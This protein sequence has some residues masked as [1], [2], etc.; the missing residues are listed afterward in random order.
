[1]RLVTMIVQHIL[2]RKGYCA[3]VNIATHMWHHR[4]C[5]PVKQQ[6]VNAGNAGL[7]ASESPMR[8]ASSEDAYLCLML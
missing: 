2:R 1:M 7:G 3:A 8:D 6:G 5:F 4:A